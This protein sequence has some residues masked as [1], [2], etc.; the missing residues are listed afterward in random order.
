MSDD[1]DNFAEVPEEVLYANLDEYNA[2][3]VAWLKARAPIKE[4]VKNFKTANGRNP[5]DSDTSE[6]YIDL[7]AYNEAEKN[8]VEYKLRMIKT[9]K[10]PFEI[11]EFN[12][13]EVA[14]NNR[15]PT[16]MMMA[17]QG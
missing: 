3:K 17:T 7:N 1:E 9:D 4:W 15:A 11:E 10:L 6:I 13:L 8:Y 16:P 14:G 12:T 2:Y 5:T